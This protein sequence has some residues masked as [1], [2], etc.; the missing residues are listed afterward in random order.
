[1]AEYAIPLTVRVFVVADALDAMTSNRTYR[2]ALPWDAAHEE[3][4]AQSG[5]QFDPQVVAAFLEC[6]ER[7]R[8]AHDAPLA[9]A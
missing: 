6:E 3:I 9:A 1:M 2:H 8:E 4:L 7:L 5:H